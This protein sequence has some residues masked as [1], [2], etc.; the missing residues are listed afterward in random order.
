MKCWN[1]D[2]CLYI[3]SVWI[4]TRKT[5]DLVPNCFLKDNSEVRALSICQNL[6]I[7]ARSPR[8]RRTNWISM[9]IMVTRF[10]WMAH[11]FV[12][13]QT[14]KISFTRFSKS[15]HSRTLE[16]LLGLE[17]LSDFTHKTLNWQ[18]ADQQLIAGALFRAAL[19]ASCL[20]G[21]FPLVDLRAVCFVRAVF[22]LAKTSPKWS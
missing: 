14:D 8:I 21:A 18:F 15:H 17:I 4:D 16:T 11:K 7:Y 12:F 3:F 9:G 2:Y 13:K 19:V 20:R 22:Q 6:S 1:W 5:P 10:A